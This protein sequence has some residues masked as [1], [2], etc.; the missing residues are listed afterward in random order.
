LTA[1]PTANITGVGTGL[2]V[3]TTMQINAVAI[4]DPGLYS[5]QPSTT[6][7]NGPASSGTG[8][9]ATLDLTYTANKDKGLAHTGWV[10]R[11]KGTGLRTGRVQQ[12]VLVA[13]GIST[14]NT[15]DD[16]IYPDS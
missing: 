14:S 3:T 9:G 13:G 7:G 6:T 8:T 4:A 1:G 2:T 11:T 15:G 10:V 16:T 5:V 12:E